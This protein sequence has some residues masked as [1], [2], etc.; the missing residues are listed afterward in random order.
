MDQQLQ[1]KGRKYAAEALVAAVAVALLIGAIAVD[2]RW[3]LS[4]FLPEFFKS[5]PWQLA[6]FTADR[7][8]VAAVAVW[9]LLWLRPRLGRAAQK[10]SVG[11]LTLDALPT[12][13]ALLLALGVSELAM[14]RLPWRARHQAPAAR[15]PLR[16][17]DPVLGWRNVPN[18]VGH[19]FVGGREIVYAMDAG[20]HRVADLARPV[21]PELPTILLVGE[22]IV[23]GHGLSWT[24]SIPAQLA[25]RTGLQ[26]ADLGVGGYATDQAYMRFAEELPRFRRPAAVVVL[27]MPKLFYRNLEVDRPHLG[28]GLAHRPPIIPLRILQLARRL[29]PYRSRR[30]IMAGEARTHEQ[31]AEVVRLARARGAIPLILVPDLER[32]APDEAAIRT[33]VLAGLPYEQVRVDP[34]WRLRGDDHPDARAATAIAEALA[35]RLSASGLKASRRRDGE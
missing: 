29:V 3:F 5:R 28:A 2:R 14:E 19:E 13:L 21:D 1:G 31:L 20:G 35:R 18:R 12:V 32:E 15:E 23:E 10:R 8:L 33:N 22:S 9:L 30:E 24:E 4:H 6:W 34:S 16:R 11:R 25:A 27:F 26:A 7:V 17:Y